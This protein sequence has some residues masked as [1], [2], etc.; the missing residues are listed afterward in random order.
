M[1]VY[2]CE[3]D[4]VDKPH[5]RLIAHRL[6]SVEQ[7][8]GGALLLL[9][10]LQS[11]PHRHPE[12]GVE[13]SGRGAGGVAVGSACGLRHDLL[14]LQEGQDAGAAAEVQARLLHLMMK[15]GD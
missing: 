10:R 1:R 9:R 6:L 14:R 13:E 12:E 4:G 3:P 11:R 15:Q 7:R 8:P 2:V 5:V